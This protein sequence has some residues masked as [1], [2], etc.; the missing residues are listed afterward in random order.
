MTRVMGIA[1]FWMALAAVAVHG[2]PAKA[3]EYGIDRPGQDYLAFDLDRP[4]PESLPEECLAACG[5]NAMCRAWTFVKAGVQGPNPRCWLKTGVPTAVRNDCCIS[6]VKSSPVV[7]TPPPEPVEPIEPLPPAITE[8]ERERVLSEGA[9]GGFPSGYSA[10][11]GPCHIERACDDHHRM[12][13]QEP[14]Q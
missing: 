6:G 10:T 13:T 7:L 2:Q 11:T 1:A 3:M 4:G 12:Q 5:R 9:G 14:D 8:A